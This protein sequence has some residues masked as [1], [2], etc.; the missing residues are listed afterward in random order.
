MKSTSKWMLAAAMVVGALGLGTASANAAQF[1]IV[2]RTGPAYVPPCP[3]PGYEW[4]AGYYDG[5]GY[6]VPGYWSYVGYSR[7]VP[8]PPGVYARFGWGDGDRDWDRERHWEHER[9]EHARDWDGDR[10]WNRD[11][12]GDHDRGEHRGWDH[13]RR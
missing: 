6:W 13:D 2:V 4:V 11:R 9:W 8:P 12:G 7:P 5:G 10:G 3:G 1:G